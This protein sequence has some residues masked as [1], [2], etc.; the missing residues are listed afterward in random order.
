MIRITIEDTKDSTKVVGQFT[1][2]ERIDGSAY[3]YMRRS[4][5]KVARQFFLTQVGQTLTL[6]GDKDDTVYTSLRPDLQ[7]HES[8]KI[9]I[10]TFE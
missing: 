4:A 6:A 2:V 1:F 3:N 5:D 8:G 10:V 7:H 9:P